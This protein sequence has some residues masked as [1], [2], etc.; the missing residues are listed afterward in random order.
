VAVETLFGVA[1]AEPG[2]EMAHV[3]SQGTH[4][5]LAV[6]YICHHLDDYCLN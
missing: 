6:G 5:A 1:A 3:V 2:P 4:E